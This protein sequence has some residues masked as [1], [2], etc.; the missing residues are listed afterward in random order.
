M[1]KSFV[2]LFTTASLP[3]L[4]C[5][6]NAEE[7]LP[8]N[9]IVFNQP[10]TNW[11]SHALPIGNGR[12]GAMFFSGV[13]SER[14]QFNEESL[15]TG[16]RNPSGGWSPKGQDN[17]S[18]GS[19]QNFGD[20]HV[21]FGGGETKFSASAQGKPLTDINVA[22]N[23]EGAANVIDGKAQSKWCFEHQGKEIVWQANLSKAAVVNSY[24]FT[25][26]NDVPERD[27]SEWTFEAS[28]DGKSW[29][30]LDKKTQ[31]KPF[32]QRHLQQNFSFNNS[33]AYKFY[34]FV[35]QPGKA[36][37]FQLAEIALPGIKKGQ[38]KAANYRR[39]LDIMSG[40][41]SCSFTKN[42]VNYKREAFVSQDSQCIVIRYTADKK[43][44]LSGALNLKDAHGAKSAARGNLL[45]T[46]GKL[47]NELRYTSAVKA[48]NKDGEIKAANE[49]LQFKNCDELTLFL[50]ART[51]YVLD[52]DK[53]FRNGI[54]P[55]AA[56]LKDLKTADKDYA[57]LKM[58]AT[59]ETA[60]YMKRVSIEL[61]D[62]PAAVKAL[63]TPER[64][65]RYREGGE[66]V[67]LEE[68]LFHFGRYL[69]QAS[70]RPG[71]LPANLQG[72]WNNKNAPAWASDYHTNI[73]IQMNYWAMEAVN[74]S[75]CHSSFIDFIDKLQEPRRLAVRSDK[76]QFG[77]HADKLRGWTCRTSENIFGGQGWNWNIPANA[78][79]AQHVWEHF[80]FTQD[81]QFLKKTGYPILKEVCHF[82]IDHLKELP[83]GTLVAPNGWS[84]EHGP[85]EDGVMH[86][87][88]MIWDLFQNT[89]EATQALGIDEDFRKTISEKQAKLAPNK[90]G[91][92]GQL[93]EWQVDRDNPKD[94]HRH[95]SQLFAVFPGRQISHALTP[96]FA[97][98]AAI[99]LTAR[100]TSG[101][102][103][104]SWTWAW[105]SALWARLGDAQRAHDMIRGLFT[106][107]MLDNMFA[108]HPPFQ[109]DGNLG[110]LA[111]YSE[112]LLQSHAGEIAI[113][114]ALCTQWPTGSVSGLRARGDIEASIKWAN[115]KL[116]SVTLSA[117]KST[118]DTPLVYASKKLQLKL[119]PGQSQT[120]SA[121]DFQ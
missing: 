23:S 38:E 37:H 79:Y 54:D 19:F 58:A 51:D 6:S 34:R 112:M 115:G 68:K 77:K 26:A 66:D 25:S 53:N 71:D 94:Q 7:N 99:S 40:V 41:H 103:R 75:D 108:T 10:G 109:I 102:S 16:G 59:A 92:W 104:R 105:R 50:A 43:G 30:V 78:W 70:S 44:A 22:K 81:K 87:Q 84:P 74:L 2:A 100:G 63:S 82:W 47:G 21:E 11:E 1:R 107:N 120:F 62:S 80:A 52:F 29:Q 86:D 15:W 93:Q 31:Q 8:A 35:F 46:Q 24:S 17:N 57:Q 113:L 61:G 20:L 56:V 27:P 98:A 13:D 14:I 64:I 117:G 67:D 106:H 110:I 114:P 69:M 91:K 89:I 42:G 85:K 28:N 119:S 49:Q 39:S 3:L 116:L 65:K 55:S 118:V 101:D 72:L 48:L 97:K 5:Q 90:I 18:F 95:T 96:A 76:K 4:S 9:E 36:S 33:Q 83:N 60:T 88:Q 45:S 121:K 73:N 111:G 12:L 32:A